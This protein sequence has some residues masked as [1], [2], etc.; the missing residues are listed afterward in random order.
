MELLFFPVLVVGAL[1]SAWSM[2]DRKEISGS[3]PW[4]LIG[5]SEDERTLEVEIRVDTGPGIKAG[6]TG[7]RADETPEAVIV[8]VDVAQS[9]PLGRPP[10]SPRRPKWRSSSMRRWV[11]GTSM[12]RPSTNPS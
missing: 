2:D 1:W 3:T 9:Y 8:G 4:R 5:I 6:V 11:I 7:V 12:P 10:T